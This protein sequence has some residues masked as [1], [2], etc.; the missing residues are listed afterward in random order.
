MPPPAD[1]TAAV[2]D[3]PTRPS[4]PRV[5]E[6][7]GR[8]RRT[9]T[10]LPALVAGLVAAL[11]PLAAWHLTQ[12]TSDVGTADLI[13]WLTGRLD[14][15]G[16][17][18]AV[19]LESRVPR[20]VAALAVG[21]ALG[22]AGAVLQSITRNPLASPDTLAV[23]SGAYLALSLASVVGLPIAFAGDVAVAFAGGLLAAG[24][25]LALAGATTAAGSRLV[26]GGTALAAAMASVTTA[27]VILRPMEARGLIA[28]SAGSLGQNGF[29]TVRW[30]LPLVVVV[31]LLA[32]VQAR[33]LDLL[34][35][36]DDHAATL[37]VPVRRARL[38]ALVT[39]VGLS[40]TA[41]ATTGP[42]DFV[43][44]A[45]PALVRLL[46]PHVPGLHRH[47][48][49][50][51]VSGLAATVLVLAADAGLR[52][53][54]GAQ[55]SIMVPT[56]TV[57]ALVGGVVVVAVALRLRSRSLGGAAASLPVPGVGVAR[58][59]VVLTVAA[60]VL[61]AAAAVAVLLGDRALLLGDVALWL[62]GDAGPLVS[63]VL[64]TRVP[65]VAAAVLAG[66]ALAVAGAAVQ[67][68][69]RNPLADP[70][71]I[72]VAG[73]ASVGAVLVV[74]LVPLSGFWVLA[75]GAGAGALAASAL[76]FALVARRGL[77]S[78]TFVL[79]GLGIGYVTTALVTVLVVAT[80]PFNA[81]KALTWLAGSTYGRT[82]A[83][84]VP[85]AVG[86]LVLVPFV[87][88][89]HRRMDLVSLDE[90]TP[91]V[92]GVAPGR[93]RAALLGAA[94]LL[95]GVAV[96]GVGLVGFVGLVA[97]H[98]ARALV[99]R[100]HSLAVPLAA[101]LGATLVLVADT[102]GRTVAAPTQLPAGLVTALVGTP[103]FLWLLARSERR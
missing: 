44:L 7:D 55:A 4:G 16:V 90:D 1:V 43:G 52:G 88:A 39:A 60:A 75:G 65:R 57:T 13:A 40:A 19:I 79:V 92:L 86:C 96:A 10:R 97:P 47:R 31:L 6:P 22:A 78:D 23:N 36:G 93:V 81:S 53:I 49:L 27:L 2:A 82:A 37:G 21:L 71:I 18:S 100:R 15:E 69:A 99:G 76:L 5:G 35:L 94:V 58:R 61:L 51:P 56:G 63:G 74:T 14:G 48:A 28:W 101:L 84:L 62:R 29:G 25:V 91:R 68:A 50:L 73:G 8:G 54:V 85:L 67:A 12:G 59:R 66:A 20:L 38:L 102:V 70:G 64:G 72:G 32:L 98:A 3:A 34:A 83:H 42:L 26:L 89:L 11:V 45:A 87:W 46:V 30:A 24:A 95:T 41:V 17:A 103:Y 9:G 77:A 33:R 80:D